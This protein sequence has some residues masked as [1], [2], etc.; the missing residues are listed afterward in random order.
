MVILVEWRTRVRNM[1]RSVGVWN[2]QQGSTLFLL[3]RILK[4]GS[5]R[6]SLLARQL[7]LLQLRRH[8]GWV[9][10]SICLQILLR[11]E[12]NRTMSWIVSHVPWANC[13]LLIVPPKIVVSEHSP[14]TQPLRP[15]GFCCLPSKPDLGINEHAWTKSTTMLYPEQPIGTGF[16]YGT[17]PKDERDVA[18]DLWQFMQNFYDVL[19]GGTVFLW[20]KRKTLN[21]DE[22]I[23]NKLM[24][25][26]P[27]WRRWYWQWMDERLSTR[28]GSHWL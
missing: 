25:V 13:F 15:A 6:F 26:H 9:S 16:S 22:N 1:R 14:V 20:T 4:I 24:D 11:C 10:H 3:V 5:L 18:A 23:N 8:D 19:S 21:D 7:Q 12:K 27:D 2:F 28:T 17:Y